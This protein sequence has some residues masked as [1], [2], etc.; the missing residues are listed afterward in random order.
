MRLKKFIRRFKEI[1]EELLETRAALAR[2]V[3]EVA[4]CAANV[5]ELL[6]DATRAANYTFSMEL[7]VYAGAGAA[8]AIELSR[9]L[10]LKTKPEA[11]F[12]LD[13]CVCIVCTVFVLI[14]IYLNCIFFAN[15]LLIGTVY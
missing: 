14:G 8:G 12:P 11:V 5:T 3:A 15:T 6:D 1:V 10:W 4:V 9:V 13:R 7:S 2:S